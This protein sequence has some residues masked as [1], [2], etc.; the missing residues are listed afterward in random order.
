MYIALNLSKL[1]SRTEITHHHQQQQR[2]S[3]WFFLSGVRC[4]SLTST[5][6]TFD[7]FQYNQTEMDIYEECSERDGKGKIKFMYF[8]M[9][10]RVNWRRKIWSRKSTIINKKMVSW[11]LHVFQFVLWNFL[12]G[13]RRQALDVIR[14]KWKAKNICWFA[15]VELKIHILCWLFSI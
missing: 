1:R 8:L 15:P 5:S 2:Q 4:C 6:S 14:W 7:Y 13:W 11:N 9:F 12:I 10:L 3:A